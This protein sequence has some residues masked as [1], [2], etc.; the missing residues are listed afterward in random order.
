MDNILQIVLWEFMIYRLKHKDSLGK[1]NFKK[2]KTCF[3]FDR[4]LYKVYTCMYT[5]FTFWTQ[6]RLTIW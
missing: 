3:T 1:E 5:N 2:N 6:V 4:T